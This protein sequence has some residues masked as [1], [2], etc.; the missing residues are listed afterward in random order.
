MEGHG[1][2]MT[3]KD[4]LRMNQVLIYENRKQPP[5]VWDIS[6]PELEE[7]AY[8][9][10]FEFLKN[11]WACYTDLTEPEEEY[12]AKHCHHHC[13]YHKML[14]PKDLLNRQRVWKRGRHQRELY[15]KAI[16][17]N[18]T[19][20]KALLVTRKGYEYECWKIVDLET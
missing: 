3:Q 7:K 15:A 9:S 5:M 8:R 20:I 2:I 6:T 14:D 13:D 10:L 19:A 11:E 16:T 17:G 1:R 4:N 18:L 12:P